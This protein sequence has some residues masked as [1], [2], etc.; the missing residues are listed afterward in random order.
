M[1]KRESLEINTSIY[2]QLIYDKGGKILLWGRIRVSSGNTVGNTR[3]L[4]AKM[5]ILNQYITLYPKSNS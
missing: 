1:N 3:Q 5:I 4:Y 2:G